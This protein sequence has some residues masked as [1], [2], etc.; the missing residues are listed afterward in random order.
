[1]SYSISLNNIKEYFQPERIKQAI[2]TRGKEIKNGL[3]SQ[4]KKMLGNAA[5]STLAT[6]LF[7]P[8]HPFNGMITGAISYPAAKACHWAC[9][10][11]HIGGDSAIGQKTASVMSQIAGIAIATFAAQCCGL[12]VSFIQACV[13]CLS[14][15]FLYIAAG[16]LAVGLIIAAAHASKAALKMLPQ[17]RSNG[18]YEKMEQ[19]FNRFSETMDHV[20]EEDIGVKRIIS[21]KIEDFHSAI[22][23][24]RQFFGIEEEDS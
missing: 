13:I 4:A 12:K 6:Y 1:M 16:A 9:K 7:T 5:T 11:L 15:N 19:V 14:T 22:N 23:E 2:Q 3:E 10:K 21:Q 24:V 20:L 18:V 8:F 17:N